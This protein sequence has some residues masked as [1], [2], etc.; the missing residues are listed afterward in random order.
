MTKKVTEIVQKEVSSSSH[1]ELLGVSCVQ[2]LSCFCSACSSFS[3]SPRAVSAVHVNSPS[4]SSLR[5][6]IPSRKF[7]IA[8]LL[9]N[10]TEVNQLHQVTVHNYLFN[11]YPFSRKLKYFRW[12]SEPCTYTSSR[13]GA[14]VL[15]FFGIS[16]WIIRSL[17][18][19][20]KKWVSNFN[21]MIENVITF[22]EL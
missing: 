3:A 6:P 1:E 2:I 21:K 4:A 9:R 12:F 16:K 8:V 13:K 11:F 22:W 5:L 19:N 18:D 10:I 14:S 17:I 20:G 15:Y 7:R